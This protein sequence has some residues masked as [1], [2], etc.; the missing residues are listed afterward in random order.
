MLVLNRKKTHM[1]NY[2]YR[3]IHFSGSEE[4]FRARF[5]RCIQHGYPTPTDG[6]THGRSHPMFVI[7]GSFRDSAKK[8]GYYG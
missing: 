2:L 1:V 8:S 5:A 4:E 6:S 3:A 7:I